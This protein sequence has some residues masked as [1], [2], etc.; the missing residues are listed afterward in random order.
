MYEIFTANSKTEKR[1]QEYIKMRSDIKEKLERLKINPRKELGA[2][3]LHGRL[4]GK[5]GAWLGSNIRIIYSIDDV[6][7]RIIIEAVGSHNVY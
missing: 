3:L 6:N 2:H 5:I 7:K 4:A 1:L